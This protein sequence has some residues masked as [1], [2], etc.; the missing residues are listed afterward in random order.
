MSIQ[1]RE[2]SNEPMPNWP[3]YHDMHVF[4]CAIV[5]P[6]VRKYYIEQFWIE[7]ENRPHMSHYRSWFSG[8]SV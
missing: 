1:L 4:K 7:G 5:Q 3:E 6:T 2:N 8:T